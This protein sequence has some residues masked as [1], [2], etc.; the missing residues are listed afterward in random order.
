MKPAVCAA[1]LALLG[2][3]ASPGAFGR[4][5]ISGPQAPVLLG[6][7]VT[8]ECLSDTD[9]DMADYT[10]EKYVKWMRSWVQLD[11]SRY[12]RC[13]YYN[14][15]VSR[16]GE[17]L[18]MHLSDITEWQ[19]G[20]YRCVKTGNQTGEDDVSE[21]L[22]IKLIDL[23]E[24]YLEKLHSFSSSVP[25]ILWAEKGSTVEVKCS[26]SSSVEP[27]Y[28]WSQEFSDWILPS[29]TLIL[30]NVNEE[31]EGRYICQARHPE[32]A[33]L[34]KTR[35]FQL[36][37]MNKSPEEV[38]GVLS[39]LSFGDILLYIAIP[40]AMLTVLLFMLLV[41]MIRHRNKQ[42]RK[43]QISLVDGEKRSPIYKGSLQSVHTTCSDTQPLVI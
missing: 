23:K 1:V 5:T 19:N 11:S 10:F 33:D 21:E 35:S 2:A 40:G 13:W 6:E 3:I 36:L 17:R 18:L 9:T 14:V 32:E 4:L 41:I 37:V 27:L 7:D 20:P 30:K 26:A 8:L 29:D 24:I 15:N 39:S 43:P 22:T 12:L 28:E 42:L 34:V 31:S 25:D 16:I 38:R